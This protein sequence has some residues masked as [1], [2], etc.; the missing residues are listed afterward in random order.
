MVNVSSWGEDDEEMDAAASE[1]DWEA[2]RS[3][4]V[5][6]DA[7]DELESS[8]KASRYNRRQFDMVK[9]IYAAEPDERF[10]GLGAQFR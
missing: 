6:D 4:E 2:A 8:G 10:Y 7:A 5:T 1:E 9:L 3:Q